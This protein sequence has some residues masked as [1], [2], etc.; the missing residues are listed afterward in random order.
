MIDIHAH[1]LP[2]IDDGA[3]SLDQSL[4]MAGIAVEDGI[5]T[6]VTTPHCLNGLYT[7]WRPDIISACAEFSR[8]LEK[9]NIPLNILPGS[10]ARLCPE[11]MDE[12]EKGRL[13]TMNDAGKYLSLELPDQFIPQSVVGF[14]NRLRD[15]GITPIITH[16]ER[17]PVIQQHVELL[18]DLISAG[19]LSQITAGSLTGDFGGRAFRCC[20]QIVEQDMLHFVA[21]D[22]HSAGSR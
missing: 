8:A 2:E 1:I 9:R 6:I 19:G 16:P 4:K 20:Q 13:M 15:R 5:S 22:A 10:E 14:I 18:Y 3:S 17:N 11:I 7:N 21:S 12:L